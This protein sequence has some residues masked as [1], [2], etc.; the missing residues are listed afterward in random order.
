MIKLKRPPGDMEPSQGRDRMRFSRRTWLNVLWITWSHRK[1]LY[2]VPS[3]KEFE[4]PQTAKF[5]RH[6]QHSSRPVSE[7]FFLFRFYLEHCYWTYERLN[8][9][10]M[11]YRKGQSN[12]GFLGR[13]LKVWLDAS[14]RYGGM[15]QNNINR[16]GRSC[17]SMRIKVLSYKKSSTY[18]TQT[19]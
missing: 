18:L 17:P 14:D 9:W 11:V 16:V 2:C 13:A 8:A 7:I 15:L 4:E 10:K 19:R 12:S 1:S 6:L 3:D 5:E